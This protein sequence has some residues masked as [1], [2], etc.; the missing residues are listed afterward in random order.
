MLT[1][2]NN[3]MKKLLEEKLTRPGIDRKFK[4][5]WNNYVRKNVVI[6]YQHFMEMLNKNVPMRDDV[7]EVI[8]KYLSQD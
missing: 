2:I 8:N 6:T 7:K 3:F 1:L 5:F 4:W